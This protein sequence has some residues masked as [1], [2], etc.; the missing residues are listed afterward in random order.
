MPHQLESHID[1][2]ESKANNTGTSVLNQTAKS[3]T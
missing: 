2:E 3:Q 1:N